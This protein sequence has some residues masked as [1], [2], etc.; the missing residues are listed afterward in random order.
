MLRDVSV[1]RIRER[2]H[3]HLPTGCLPR[4]TCADIL[5]RGQA[6]MDTVEH[7]KG[8]GSKG[9]A[10][11]A[12]GAAIQWTLAFEQRGKEYVVTYTLAQLHLLLVNP[13]GVR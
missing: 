6:A 11:E 10:V 9:V 4:L 2:L 12:Q 8:I 3:N 7:T 1:L 5:L 13:E